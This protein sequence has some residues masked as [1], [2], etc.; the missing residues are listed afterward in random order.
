MVKPGLWF[1]LFFEADREDALV[2][3]AD[4]EDVVVIEAN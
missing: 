4:Q 2:F 1:G 3:E